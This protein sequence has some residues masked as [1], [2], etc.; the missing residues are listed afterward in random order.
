MHQEYPKS[1]YLKGWE[2]LDATVVVYDADEEAVMRSSG[3][4][5]LA[6]PEPAKTKSK[7]KAEAE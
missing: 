6:D 4:K 3:Y 2:D 1:L 5:G 7:A